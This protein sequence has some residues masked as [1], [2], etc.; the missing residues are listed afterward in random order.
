M[1]TLRVQIKKEEKK[2]K[3][4][5]NLFATLFTLVFLVMGTGYLL[6][7]FFELTVGWYFLAASALIMGLIYI[8]GLNREKGGT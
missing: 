7:A 2:A 3:L 1:E 8:I 4:K 5:D 6:V